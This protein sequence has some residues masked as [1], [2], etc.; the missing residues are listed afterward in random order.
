MRRLTFIILLGVVLTV[1]TSTVAGA[2]KV[3]VPPQ[4]QGTYTY[5]DQGTGSTVTVGY[6]CPGVALPGWYAD[7]WAIYYAQIQR[8][9][10]KFGVS[11]TAHAPWK[12]DVSMYQYYGVHLA[13]EAFQVLGGVAATTAC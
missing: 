1:S 9:G 3:T 13:P 11:V 10:N 5:R 12:L 7:P 6:V 8:Q 4:V 2:A